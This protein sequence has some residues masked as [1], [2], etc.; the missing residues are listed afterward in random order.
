V[1]YS[2][3]YH[4]ASLAA[5]FLALGIGIL[6]GVGFGDSLVS[7][8]QRNL[9]ESLSSDLNDARG[10]AG[11]A[12]QELERERDFSD[13]VYPALVA[14]RLGGKKLAVIAIGGLPKEL[15]KDIEDAVD[16]SGARITE[17][18][19][20]RAPPD[21]D[22]LAEKLTDEK[23]GFSGIRT[24]SDVLEEFSQQ[25]G[26]ELVAGGTLV[27][28]LRNQVLSRVSG[29]LGDVDG[30][31]LV[32]DVPDDLDSEE[33]DSLDSLEA[34]L[35]RGIVES[36]V[37]VVAVERSEDE[38]SNVKF[39]EGRQIS[40]VDS[41]DLVSGRVAM[42][43]ALRGAEGSFGIKDTADRLLPELLEVSPQG[44]ESGAA[45]QR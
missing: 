43:F 30:V 7:S 13:Q 17:V 18:A 31:I 34:G 4:A 39:F 37:P 42:V 32:R 23:A 35:L 33:R 6:V 26:K 3:R 41:L 12:R 27:R 5:V 40:T 10:D 16:P 14:H 11:K 28:A 2:A 38:H 20:V 8:T 25:T 15:S 44:R 29:N 22:A 36:G 9:E 19:V 24:D 45:G 21:L 1:G